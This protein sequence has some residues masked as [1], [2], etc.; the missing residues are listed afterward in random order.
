MSEF[1]VQPG[2]AQHITTSVRD[3][4]TR[5]PSPMFIPAAYRDMYLSMVIPAAFRDIQLSVF[6]TATYRDMRLSLLIPGNLR[7]PPGGLPGGLPGV[8]M[9]SMN[10][11]AFLPS[12]PPPGGPP[13][14]ISPGA[15]F[16][17]KKN[18]EFLIW[19]GGY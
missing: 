9:F 2:Q 19:G 18:C 3:K 10:V 1:E 14:G 6:I 5:L 8:L 12:P 7:G 11:S 17:F 16:F 13:R 15:A 4:H